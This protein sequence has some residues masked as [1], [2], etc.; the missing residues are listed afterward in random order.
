MFVYKQAQVF[1]GKE[2][3]GYIVVFKFGNGAPRC[4]SSKN[5]QGAQK[6]GPL[7]AFFYSRPV[8][9]EQTVQKDCF[10]TDTTTITLN[11]GQFEPSAAASPLF[12]PTFA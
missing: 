10:V 5:P 12:V 11:H 7:L 3:T 4:F 2:Y 9:I 1:T 8:A 6:Y